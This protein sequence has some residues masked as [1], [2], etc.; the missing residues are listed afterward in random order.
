[1]LSVE[2]SKLE[3]S[4]YRRGGSNGNS[5]YRAAP[6]WRTATFLSKSIGV[7]LAP[8]KRLTASLW[9]MLNTSTVSRTHNHPPQTRTSGFVFNIGSMRDNA[10]LLHRDG[11]PATCRTRRTGYLSAAISILIQKTPLTSTYSLKRGGS[12][13]CIAMH[14]QSVRL[15]VGPTQR[16]R[17]TAC[18]DE[19]LKVDRSDLRQCVTSPPG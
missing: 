14:V 8:G 17:A 13:A 1:M 3:N 16:R 5:G 19:T 6:M 9:T 12:Q 7:Y 11:R 10:R 4:G 15:A 18:P 2:V